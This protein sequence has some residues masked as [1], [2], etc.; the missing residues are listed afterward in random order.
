VKERLL[1]Y[2]LRQAGD[3]AMVILDRAGRQA[4]RPQQMLEHGR[5]QVVGAAGPD[6]LDGGGVNDTASYASSAAA[7]TVHLV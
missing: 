6:A 5:K 7:V 4:P 1:I 3:I 2:R